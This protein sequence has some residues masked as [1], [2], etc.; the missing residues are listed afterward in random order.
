[1]YVTNV[2]GNIVS[3]HHSTQPFGNSDSEPFHTGK[4]VQ[5][6]A[7]SRH[8]SRI[9]NNSRTL[10]RSFSRSELGSSNIPSLALDWRVRDHAR[11]AAATFGMR[12][13]EVHVAYGQRFSNS[14]LIGLKCFNGY[15]S[16]LAISQLNERAN[17]HHQAHT[18]LSCRKTAMTSPEPLTQR[19]SKRVPLA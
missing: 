10:A 8:S 6:S 13:Y 2:S 9:V 16:I 14:L 3:R 19:K 4:S 17:I 7:D 15:E 1:M 18:N 12:S 5:V 11:K